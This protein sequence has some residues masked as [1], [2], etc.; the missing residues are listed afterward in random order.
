MRKLNGD[1][2]FKK[3]ELWSLD[4]TFS[5]IIHDGLLQFRNMGRHG[6]P[7]GLFIDG[8]WYV[9]VSKDDPRLNTQALEDYDGKLT[10]HHYISFDQLT[11]MWNKILDDMILAFKITSEDT[12]GGGYLISIS[13]NDEALK[14][15]YFLTESDKECVK[16]YMKSIHDIDPE[17]RTMKPSTEFLLF[18]TVSDK[19]DDF[20]LKNRENFARYMSHLWD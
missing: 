19:V 3:E 15:L 10:E 8:E 6:E 1:Y 4:C 13:D 9:S 16:N 2:V 17:T 5:K 20:I 18:R 7:G 12:D 11:E 14:E